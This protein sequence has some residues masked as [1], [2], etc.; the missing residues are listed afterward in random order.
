MSYGGGPDTSGNNSISAK[1]NAT[2]SSGFSTVITNYVK[3]W[4]TKGGDLL[5]WYNWAATVYNSDEGTFGVTNNQYNQNTTKQFALRSFMA[6][7]LP[8]V[9]IGDVPPFTLD[10]ADSVY[11][12]VGVGPWT[13]H[14]LTI[15]F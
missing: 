6:G 5:T 15:L 7:T 8:K 2:L 10:G 9:T 13:V 14:I 4:Y 11:N 1:A 3:D 12:T